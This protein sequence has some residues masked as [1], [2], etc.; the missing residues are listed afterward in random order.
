[1]ITAIGVDIVDV[2]RI[3]RLMDRHGMKFVSRV[4]GERE[5]TLLRSRHD[6]A[7]F[8][9]GRFAAKEALVK[10]FG[11]YL[12]ERPGFSQIEILADS[13]GRPCVACGF[14]TS[15]ALSSVRMLVSISHEKSYA[16]AMAILSEE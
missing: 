8:V 5:A 15:D 9:A 6:A 2:T 12:T 16:V 3:R 14:P 10:A 4:L 11:K 7:Q 13:A 1:M